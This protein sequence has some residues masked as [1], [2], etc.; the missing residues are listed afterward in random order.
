MLTFYLSLLPLTFD[1]HRELDVS[2][3]HDLAVFAQMGAH[4][5][6]QA[7]THWAN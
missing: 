3:L 6:V 5:T 2:T 1:T 7:Y 4:A